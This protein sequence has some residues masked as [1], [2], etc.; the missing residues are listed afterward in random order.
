MSYTN[1]G[2]VLQAPAATAVT[3]AVVEA[4]RAAAR[5]AVRVA[6]MGATKDE[7]QTMLQTA[8]IPSQNLMKTT[9]RE[10]MTTNTNWRMARRRTTLRAMFG[11][12]F[13][14]RR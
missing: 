4:A 3:V 11:K 10:T 14:S 6:A 2:R 8:S 9:I 13:A 5:A 1:Q 7:T 12:L